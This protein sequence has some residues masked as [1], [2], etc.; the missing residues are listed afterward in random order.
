[1]DTLEEGDEL[2]VACENILHRLGWLLRGV[3]REV[4]R[5]LPR[6]EHRYR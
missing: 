3:H 4:M 2:I 6:E 1:M 5:D